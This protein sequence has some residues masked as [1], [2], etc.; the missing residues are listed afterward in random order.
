[1]DVSWGLSACCDFLIMK[2]FPSSSL[3][4]CSS[5]LFKTAAANE[6]SFILRPFFLNSL[7]ASVTNSDCVT[8]DSLSSVAGE[9][10]SQSLR[11]RFLLATSSSWFAF[12]LK[13]VVRS[14]GSP[15]I[16]FVGWP[17][18]SCFCAT[19]AFPTLVDCTLC[20]SLL[21][22][23]ATFVIPLTFGFLFVAFAGASFARAGLWGAAAIA[24][25]SWFILLLQHFAFHWN[26]KHK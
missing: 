1:M 14:Q 4:S 20:S 15:S 24:A 6:A 7:M 8:P 26:P 12:L 3:A 16:G 25:P 21:F 11:G 17:F 9:V 2:H 5:T 13:A 18:L 19:T 22:D 10:F 23:A